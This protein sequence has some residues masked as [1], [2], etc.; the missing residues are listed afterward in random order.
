MVGPMPPDS[1]LI[2]L[3]ALILLAAAIGVTQRFFTGRLR[4]ATG[5]PL[6]AADLGTGAAFGSRATLVQFSTPTCAQCPGTA[7]LLRGIA[8]EHDGVVH[9]EVDLTQHP[10]LAD[11]FRVLQTPTTLVV[12][13]QHR[14]RA[15][16]G[17]APR[18]EALTQ[19]LSTVL[20]GTDVH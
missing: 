3:A 11:R 15:R 10:R 17:G 19:E 2:A 13:A 14:V 1:A 18:R 20:G 9:L 5:E 8:G 6:H 12:D 7:R 16:I 4:R